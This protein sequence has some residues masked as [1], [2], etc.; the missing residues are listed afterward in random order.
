MRDF[1]SYVDQACAALEVNLPPAIA[2][3]NA[4][5]GVQL[6][7][8]V[9]YHPGGKTPIADYPA[10]E[11]SIADGTG[12]RLDVSAT[13]AELE[14]PLYAIWWMQ[15]ADYDTLKRMAWR[16]VRALMAVL[17]QHDVVGASTWPV[18]FEQHTKTAV[19]PAARDNPVFQSFAMLVVRY[20]TIEAIALA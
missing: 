3:L 15:D 18:S 13:S 16:G 4:L 8:P 12:Q 2:T 19:D 11:V 9:A 20:R 14:V 10:V 17:I 6:G 1:G 7:E 5:G